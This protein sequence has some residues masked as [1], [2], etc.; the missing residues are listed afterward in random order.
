M[1]IIAIA[2][3]SLIACT[4]FIDTAWAVSKKSSRK[5]VKTL[6]TSSQVKKGE[7]SVKSHARTA[8]NKTKKDN[9]STIGNVN[10]HTGKK[11]TKRP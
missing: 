11:G 4:L 1:K 8:R 5:T 10:P 9:W 6:S 2:I 3:A 7:V